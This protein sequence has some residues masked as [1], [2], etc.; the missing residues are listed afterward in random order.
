MNQFIQCIHQLCKKCLC[1]IEITPVM[2]SMGH[3]DAVTV[4]GP[5]QHTVSSHG[6]LQMRSLDHYVYEILWPEP[7]K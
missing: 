4:Q 1:L 5:I 7:A 3:N 6:A 2:Y